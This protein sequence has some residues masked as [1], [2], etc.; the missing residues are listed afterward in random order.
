VEAGATTA[1]T[2]VNKLVKATPGQTTAQ[3]G[4]AQVK[5]A[6]NLTGIKAGA[7]DASSATASFTLYSDSSCAAASSVGSAGP[8]ALVYGNPATTASATMS[9]VITIA[10]SITYYWR[11][12]YSGDAFNNGFTTPCSQ[13]SVRATF[14]FVG[15]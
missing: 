13:E 3:V 11:V 14:T 15:Q 6:I 7:S 5:D 1:C 10:P 9:T 8:V 4:Y 2:I 12:T